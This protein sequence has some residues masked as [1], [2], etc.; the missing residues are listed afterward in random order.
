MLKDFNTKTVAD[1]SSKFM[2]A[3]ENETALSRGMIKYDVKSAALSSSLLALVNPMVMSAGIIKEFIS[4][5]S[6]EDS[7]VLA[8]AVLEN[9]LEE[10][11]GALF[12]SSYKYE[13]WVAEYSGGNKAVKTA[14]L[15][16]KKSILTSVES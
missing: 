13:D 6:S 7:L 14:L 8:M 3:N 2:A 10:A 12:D 15:E 4:E 9:E 11:E 1:Y 5:K 16:H